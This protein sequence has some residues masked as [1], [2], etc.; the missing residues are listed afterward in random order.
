MFGDALSVL[1]GELK[2][3]INGAT[4][5]RLSQLKRW[6]QAAV[7]KS[8]LWSVGGRGDDFFFLSVFCLLG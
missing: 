5:S 6:M 3:A 4:A 1:Y 7:S 8:Q 2:A